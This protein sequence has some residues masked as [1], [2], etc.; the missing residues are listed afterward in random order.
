MLP[1]CRQLDLALAA[2]SIKHQ[3]SSSTTQAPR[4]RGFFVGSA[5]AIHATKIPNLIA[6]YPIFTLEKCPK[7]FQK[8][9][10]K[11]EKSEYF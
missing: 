2:A 5:D 4:S 8:L 10:I 1:I 11:D 7:F 3:F 6:N 9:G